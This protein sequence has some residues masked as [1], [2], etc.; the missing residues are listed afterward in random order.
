MRYTNLLTLLVHLHKIL[1]ILGTLLIC[2]RFVCVENNEDKL[3]IVLKMKRLI[4]VKKR[5]CPDLAG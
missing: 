5:R 2:S 3:I 4:I 1:Y